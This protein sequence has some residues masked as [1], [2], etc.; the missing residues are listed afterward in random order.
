MSC[1]QFILALS[2][3]DRQTEDTTVFTASQFTAYKALLFAHTLS[4]LIITHW[5]F[6]KMPNYFLTRYT[7][8]FKVHLCITGGV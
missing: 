5:M 1:I 4:H 7:R 8:N 6:R 2:T 3:T